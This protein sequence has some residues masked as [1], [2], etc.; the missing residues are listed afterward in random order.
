M[1]TLGRGK[2][3]VF[4]KPKLIR[5]NCKFPGDFSTITVTYFLKRH[6]GYYLIQVYFP[7]IFVVALSWIVFWMDKNDMG[8]RMAIGITTIL[9]IT[10]LLGSLNGFMPRVSYPKA[11]DWY[12]LVSFTLTFLSLVECMI[13]FVVSMSENKEHDDQ[14]CLIVFVSLYFLGPVH[15]YLF[16]SENRDFL[17][18][19]KKKTRSHLVLYNPFCPSTRKPNSDRKWYPP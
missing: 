14:V 2:W 9:T 10:F 15:M 17:S 13:V 8:N 6:I 18:L 1:P 16:L 19:S 11:L 12:L 4:R 3:A 7:D 5:K